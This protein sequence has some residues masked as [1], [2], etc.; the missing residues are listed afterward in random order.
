MGLLI[1][2]VLIVFFVFFRGGGD[3]STTSDQQDG[4]FNQNPL[5]TETVLAG[6][7]PVGGHGRSRAGASASSAPGRQHSAPDAQG[8]QG[9]AVQAGTPSGVTPA[10]PG[11]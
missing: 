5:P 2:C 8:T 7:W 6:C 4:T 1:L 9:D 10:R 3:A 11:R